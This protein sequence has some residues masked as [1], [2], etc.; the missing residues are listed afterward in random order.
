MSISINTD[1]PII[2]FSGKGKPFPYDKLFYATVEPYILEFKNARLE[3]L[4]EDDAARCLV[5]VFKR[6]EVNGVPVL[7]FF[8]EDLDQWSDL[9]QYEKTTRLA[10]LMAKDIF[11]CFDK[12]RINGDGTFCRTNRLYSVTN[13]EGIRD[14]II[15]DTYEKAGMFK[16][17]PIAETIY[18]RQLMDQFEKGWLPKKKEE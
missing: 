6:M 3:K 7:E 12:N 18:F 1:N 10:E 8:K 15:C 14:F 5:R 17:T 13:A 4:T 2:K 9:S 16:K 11:C